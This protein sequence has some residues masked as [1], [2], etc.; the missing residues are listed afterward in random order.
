LTDRDLALEV[1]ARGAAPQPGEQDVGANFPNKGAPRSQGAM[2]MPSGL[3]HLSKTTRTPVSQNIWIKRRRAP[4]LQGPCMATA[5]LS[6]VLQHLRRLHL[7][8]EDD[9]LNDGELLE[10]FFLHGDQTAFEV[11]VRRY[12]SMVLGV[13]KKTCGTNCDCCLT[14]N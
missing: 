6:Q 11:L 3:I 14:R 9:K 4:V 5:Q 1:V 2:R 10:R 12:G 8:G 13:L 7:L